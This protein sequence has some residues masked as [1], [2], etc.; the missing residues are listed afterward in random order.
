MK[1][2]LTSILFFSLLSIQAQL[3][4]LNEQII[5]G[6][7]TETM[8]SGLKQLRPYVQNGRRG[9]KKQKAANLAMYAKIFISECN[10]AY[11]R[12]N[13]IIANLEKRKKHELASNVE[14]L[15]SEIY[16][17]KYAANALIMYCQ[18]MINKP[19][20]H[21]G[22]TFNSCVHAFNT[23]IEYRNKLSKKRKILNDVVATWGWD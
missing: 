16:N 9:I 14:D 8:R 20:K 1:Q 18:L 13:K 22:K 10:L 7:K 5:H 3:G 11:A 6:L 4:D 17:M 2:V 21:K 19:K 23:I 15:R 12:A